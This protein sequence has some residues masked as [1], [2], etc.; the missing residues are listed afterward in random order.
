[1]E[2]VRLSHVALAKHF[3]PGAPNA[4]ATIKELLWLLQNQTVAAR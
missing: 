4:E 2:V 3:L 1:L